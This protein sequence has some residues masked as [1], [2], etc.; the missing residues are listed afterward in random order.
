MPKPDSSKK[1][2]LARLTLECNQLRIEGEGLRQRLLEAEHLA[3]QREQTLRSVVEEFQQFAYAASH[4]L[5]EP[6]RVINSYAQLIERSLQHENPS[7][8]D[9]EAVEF[10]GYIQS[11]VARMTVLLQDL[12]AYSRVPAHPRRSTVNL[13]GVVEGV[14]LKLYRELLESKAELTRDVLP[15]VTGDEAL[16]AQVLAQLVSNGIKF[17][18]ADAPSIHI[19]AVE[20][21]TETVV[22]V[23]DNGQGIAARFQTQVFGVFKRL[24]GREIPGTGIGLAMCHKIVGCHGGRIW[25]ESDG[26]T[27]STFFFSIPN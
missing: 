14:R 10:L 19:A 3:A 24:H 17:R 26:R 5:Q 9:A 7:E 6:L 11:G 18:G 20:S 15:E 25:V 23:R 27:G 21:D 22:S 16:L 8:S 1:A 4:D 2:D 13:E 12:L